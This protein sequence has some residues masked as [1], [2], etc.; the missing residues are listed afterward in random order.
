MAVG[1]LPCAALAD[2]GDVPPVDVFPTTPEASSTRPA[3]AAPRPGTPGMAHTPRPGGP[4][5]APPPA[6]PATISTAPPLPNPTPSNAPAPIRSAAPAASPGSP[7]A[8]RKTAAAATAKT[9]PEADKFSSLDFPFLDA[10]TNPKIA[11]PE[12]LEALRAKL[13]F[14]SIPDRGRDIFNNSPDGPLAVKQLQAPKVEK[15]PEPV[16]DYFLQAVR[17]LRIEMISPQENMAVLNGRDIFL[18]DTVIMQTG[19][20]TTQ[21]R[22]KEIKPT[23]IVFENPV[24]HHVTSLSIPQENDTL[25]L[26]TG[27]AKPEGLEDIPGIT[28]Q[29]R[30]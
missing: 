16:I 11:E 15:A 9:P 18:G 4:R 13:A 5:P 27:N 10:M 8:A 26:N 14:L 21:A 29:E 17:S 28:L 19:A 25:Q 7:A 3:Q 12:M 1:L 24:D 20:F 23:T 22:V 2:S 6:N 30:R